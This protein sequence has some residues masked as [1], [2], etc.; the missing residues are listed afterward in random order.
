MCVAT[1]VHITDEFT[2]RRV[3][4]RLYLHTTGVLRGLSE[5]QLCLK[6][7]LETKTNYV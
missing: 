5:R 2:L 3:S 6:G 4:H 1:G 7:V